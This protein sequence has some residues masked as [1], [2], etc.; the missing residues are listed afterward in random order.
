VIHLSNLHKKWWN[1]Q[2][3]ILQL[4]VWSAI[5]DE[6]IKSFYTFSHSVEIFYISNGS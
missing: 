4:H 6:P 5:L 1:V 3:W 2:N